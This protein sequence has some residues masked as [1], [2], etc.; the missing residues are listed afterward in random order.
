MKGNVARAEGLVRSGP[1][2]ERVALFYG[3][4][5]GRVSE[6]AQ[7]L[8]KK[9]VDDLTDPFRVVTLDPAVLKSDPAALVAE[10]DAIAFGGGRR[11]IRVR[12]A[13][14]GITA[15][16]ASVL[17]HGVGDGFVVLE[18]AELT[19]RSGLRKLCDGHA[20]ALSVGCYPDDERA[21][22]SLIESVVEGFSLTIDRDARAAVMGF[23]GND[24]ALNRS[25]LE[26]LCFF[27]GVGGGLITVADVHA[28]LVD[29]GES[30]SDGIILQAF[31]GRHDAVVAQFDRLDV[32]GG[33]TAGVVRQA[34]SLTQ[35]F[36]E[37]RGRVE[38]GTSA[39]SAVDGLRPP[40]F[41]AIKPLV[42]RIVQQ[43]PRERLLGALGVLG[44]AEVAMRGG[45]SIDKEQA[46]RCFFQIGQM[47]RRLMSNR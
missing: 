13:N 36:I 26:K 11:V 16:V 33:S 30:R 46:E 25:E 21:Q 45:L 6:L 31:L 47:G 17:E 18:A 7:G 38:Q 24:R 9:I 12:G 27:K 35:R 1:S 41:F 5:S 32:E 29:S 15:S 3:P 40:I 37:A 23:L 34:I 28:C 19:P 43:W 10:V 44:D 14:D 2:D 22:M 8:S 4:D 20:L 39:S 42:V